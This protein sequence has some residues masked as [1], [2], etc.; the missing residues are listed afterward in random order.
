MNYDG[1]I[2]TVS[3]SDKLIVYDTDAYGNKITET[4][5][6]ANESVC[7]GRIFVYYN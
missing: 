6:T 4:T 5:I 7:G 3:Y 2:T 1:S